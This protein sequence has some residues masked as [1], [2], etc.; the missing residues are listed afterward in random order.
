MSPVASFPVSQATQTLVAVDC[1][2]LPDVSSLVIRKRQRDSLVSPS[3]LD[4][5]L[6]DHHSDGL[7]GLRL[8]SDQTLR[9]LIDAHKVHELM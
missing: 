1:C 9:S 3:T 2:R 6:G 7:G 5:E 4:A 8:R